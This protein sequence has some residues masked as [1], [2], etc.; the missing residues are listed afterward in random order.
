MSHED[1]FNEIAQIVRESDEIFHELVK[2]NVDALLQQMY[3][4][5]ATNQEAVS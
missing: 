5:G 3:A 1:M 4:A 2:I